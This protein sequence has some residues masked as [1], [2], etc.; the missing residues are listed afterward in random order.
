MHV[1]EPLMWERVWGG[2]MLRLEWS[3]D[4]GWQVWLF[5]GAPG[6]YRRDRLVRDGR[7]LS[8]LVDDGA[9][10]DADTDAT[11][12]L[13]DLVRLAGEQRARLVFDWTPGNL[14]S[15]LEAT[16]FIRVVD[17]RGEEHTLACTLTSVEQEDG[18][19]AIRERT[20]IAT[21]PEAVERL[22]AL[23]PYLATLA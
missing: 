10:A 9:A 20:T 12:A 16:L 14:G 19:Q 11:H 13:Q 18:V 15:R 7:A 17:R 6:A 23:T 5:R 21:L 22:R 3:H 1:L 8:D 4:F 2:G